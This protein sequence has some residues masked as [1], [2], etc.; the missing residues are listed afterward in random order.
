MAIVF[1]EP[2]AGLADSYRSLVHEF[3]VA[4][5]PLVPF[6]LAIPAD[7]FGEFLGRLAACARGEGLPRGFVPHS[8]YWLVDN[9][10][11][12]AVSN[13]RHELTD[14]LRREGG[15]IGYGVRPSA[16]RRGFATVILGKTLERARQRGLGEALLTCA[17]A[18]VGSTRAIQHNGGELTSEEFI[19]KR[20]EL[21]QRWRIDLSRPPQGP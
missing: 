4:S 3:T 12:V 16:R 18:N 2:H 5:E 1:E 21:I 17:K 15:N 8:T 13:L 11:V 14:A 7:D 9:G 10:E 19:P 20:G 6:V